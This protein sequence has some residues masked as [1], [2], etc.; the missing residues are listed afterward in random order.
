M[1]G[2]ERGHRRPA[3]E[4]RDWRTLGG[5]KLHDA[6]DEVLRDCGRP[7]PSRELA[8]EINRRQFYVRPSDGEAGGCTRA[9]ADLPR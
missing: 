2:A 5:V 6:I 3:R 4:P 1:I 9:P 8:D 7:M